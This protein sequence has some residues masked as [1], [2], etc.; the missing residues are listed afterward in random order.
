[1]KTNTPTHTPTPW[2]QDGLSIVSEHWSDIA[3]IDNGATDMDA[4]VIP[5]D[6]AYANAAFIVTAVNSHEELKAYILRAVR[7]DCIDDME[8]ERCQVLNRAEGRI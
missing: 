5:Q 6:E 7:C 8:C 4:N 2:T 1:M 3:I